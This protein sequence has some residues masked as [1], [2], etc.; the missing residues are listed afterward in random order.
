MATAP[1]IDVEEETGDEE[2]P[3]SVPQKDDPPTYGE[4]NRDLPKD[5]KDKLEGIVKKLQDQ[6]MY[7]RR[8]EVLL[9][10][11]LRFYYDGIQHVY[12]NWA[13]GVYQV[14]QAGGFVDIGNG[15]NVQCPMFMGAY[16]IF[17]RDWRSMDAVL[18]QNPPGIGFA[19]NDQ[20][21]ESI[22]AAETAEGF[23]MV[24]DQAE[25]GGQIKRIQ[26]RASYLFGMSGRV[27]TWTRTLKSRS[28]FGANDE[29]EARSMETCD[30]Y[31]T[32]ES[33]VPIVC[34]DWKQAPYCFL[35]DDKN[36]LTLKAENEWI[37]DK[38]APGEASIGDS[39]WN[40]FARIGVKQAKK[41]FFL[42]G[43]ALNYLTTELNG[44]LRP[45]VFQDK[46]FDDPYPG[47]DDGTLVATRGEN[48]SGKP[49]TY[50]D[51]FLQLFPDGCHVKWVGKTYSESWN[52]CPDDA[53][54]V[55]FPIE[56]DGMTGG[57]LMEPDKVIQDAFND[58]MNAKR[59][60]Y[61]TGWSVTY[62]RGS[63]EDYQAISNQPS[64][65]NNYV[66]LKEG[67]PDQEIAKSVIHR[68]D[69]AQPPAGFDEAIAELN[70]MS[71][72]LTGALP[73]LQ[74]DSKASQ[75]ASGQAMDRS[76]AMGQLGPAWGSMQVMFSG[77]AEKAARLASKN[78]DHGTEIAVVGSDGSKVTVKLE[79]LKKG[80]FHAHVSDSSFPETTAAKRS[81]LADLVKMAEQSPVG[82]AIFESPDNWL[83]FI[84]L[85]GNPDLVLIPAIAYKKQT[86]ELEELLQSAPT[87]PTP[88]DIAAAAAAH[89]KQQIE[90]EQQAAM[91]GL[92]A[93]I[94]AP[95]QPPQPQPS[96]MP[97]A[98]DYHQWES[99]K[100]QEYL[101]SEDCW[102]RMNVAPPDQDP[103]QALQQAKLGIQNVRLHKAVHDQF[104]AQQ[105]MQKAQMAQVM[106]P[107]A[108]SIAFKDEDP[109]GKQQMN[110][111]AGIKEA[112][113]EAQGSVQKNAASPGARGTATV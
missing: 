67:P 28:R 12:P 20:S 75:T 82:Q 112:A 8:V 108:E 85:N 70:T 72:D 90:A 88:E 55:A 84:E 78:P 48:E 94:P 15:Q 87:I 44:F 93:P 33:K 43:L 54:D 103:D 99:A 74:G 113:P 110:A 66:L 34:R 27:V 47:G 23:W 62:F 61:E 16:N 51:A 68:E 2:S 29:G 60:N 58:Y 89:A 83:E 52:E 97:E 59:E 100:C 91:Q 104:L 7:D 30:V 24:F 77:I 86:R 40:R 31:G 80:N 6:E 73:A 14:G 50:R 1:L 32:M 92:P 9:D 42:T 45:E 21:S 39:D 18:T 102:L 17:R 3:D 38:I 71:H 5:L 41:G 101:S 10:R 111:Q 36:A 37:R 109:A 95:F 49:F 81:N 65:P 25:K 106:K 76:Q 69:P 79:R 19:P 105:A 22:E 56:R 13:T 57:A 64:R 11:I 46:L 107:P 4:K 26:K 53:I 96:L 35:F 98:D 63:D